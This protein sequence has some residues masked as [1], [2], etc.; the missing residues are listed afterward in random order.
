MIKGKLF[1]VN[2]QAKIKPPKSPS[3]PLSSLSAMTVGAWGDPHLYISVSSLDSKNRAS[4]KTIAQWGDNKP[5]TAGNNELQLLDLQT[6]TASIKIYYTNKAY[7]SAKVI[8]T[9]RVVYNAVS[10]TYNSTTKLTLGPVALNILKIGS[11]ASAYLTFEM[12]WSNINNIVKLGGAL[13][14]ILKRVA[15]NNGVLWNGGDGAT[16]DGFGKALA[17][18]GLNRSSFETGIGVQS[19]SEDLV[20]SSD[21]ANFLAIIGDSFTQNGSIFDNLQNLGENG[22]GDNAAIGDW[23][24]THA[25]VLPILSD[26]SGLEGSIDNVFVSS[27]TPTATPTTTSTVTPT[28]TVTATQT[29]TPTTTPTITPTVTATNTPTVTSTP[30]S[31]PGPSGPTFS[32]VSVDFSTSD[33]AQFTSAYRTFT[34]SGS[35]TSTLNF[36]HNFT[37]VPGGTYGGR[38]RVYFTL[39]TA[40]R[41]NT[42]WQFSGSSYPSNYPSPNLAST[43]SHPYFNVG[44]DGIYRM[45][46]GYTYHSTSPALQPMSFDLQAGTYFFEFVISTR[47]QSTLT[48][49]LSTKPTY[50]KTFTGAYYSSLNGSPWRG[51]DTNYAIFP[52]GG[53]S[54]S[55]LYWTPSNTTT[56]ISIALINGGGWSAR[57]RYSALTASGRSA[58][59]A[60][61]WT[62]DDKSYTYNKS[63]SGTTDLTIPPLGVSSDNWVGIYNAYSG[64]FTAQILS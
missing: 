41:V 42:S 32:S 30:S 35:G 59:L 15:D 31:T 47:S 56:V 26:T 5:G 58:L 12:S 45:S 27:P 33:S 1:I 10:T 16:W 38:T 20:L 6:S 50:T 17:P 24:P 21:E 23:D 3:A 52:G 14:P 37:Q 18:Y 61:G 7:G 13:V 55:Y 25:E 8:D 9:I 49:T 57:I 46:L 19:V 29:R 63:F 53:S 44:K 54:A 22:E 36:T 28:P 60:A 62:F 40:A 34:T 51:V 48:A 4:T 64:Q 2:G 43:S 39:A 11:G